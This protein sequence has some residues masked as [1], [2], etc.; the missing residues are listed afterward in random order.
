M[1]SKELEPDRPV[2][3]S[4]L[5]SI[6]IWAWYAL[7]IDSGD[8]LAMIINKIGAAS[9]AS[10]EFISQG[11]MWSMNKKQWQFDVTRWWNLKLAGFQAKFVNTAQGSKNSPFRPY[12]IPPANDYEWDVCRNQVIKDTIHSEVT[13][14]SFAN[15]TEQKIRSAKY[16]NFSILGLVLTYSL[17]ALIVVISFA[18]PHI[19]RFMQKRGW[20]DKY[21]YLEWEGDTAIQLHRVAQDELGYG[22]WSSCDDTIPITR[23]DDLLA[24]FDI[25][26]PSH[27]MLVRKL[28][29]TAPG[30]TSPESTRQSLSE[31]ETAQESSLEYS[32]GEANLESSAGVRRAFT[33]AHVHALRGKYFQGRVNE[34][35]EKYQNR[36]GTAP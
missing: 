18:I 34:E 30:E 21:S 15:M 35:L 32:D 19:L 14:P 8:N 22:H 17:G 7:S 20:Y 9:L 12:M 2:S 4:K 24:P 13:R 36:P 33:D 6:I 16:A 25:S 27:P 29:D 31:E 28:G 10:Q 11:L 3:Q 5:G 26:D 1:T 23:P